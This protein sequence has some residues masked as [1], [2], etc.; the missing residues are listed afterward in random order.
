M[1]V[2]VRR[3]PFNRPAPTQAPDLALRTSQ[4]RVLYAIMPEPEHLD[5]PTLW[6]TYTRTQICLRTGTSL[7][8]MSPTRALNGV[9]DGSSSDIPHLGLLARGMVEEVII[10]V[11][12]VSESAYHITTVGIS[13]V[14]RFLAAHG[15]KMPPK[16]DG[17]SC[18]NTRYKKDEGS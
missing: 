10:D 7:R 14:N 4:A 8:S 17:Q 5:D 11:E 16:R 9:R 12:G 1:P 15:G 13:A 6:P 18:I 2:S 3:S